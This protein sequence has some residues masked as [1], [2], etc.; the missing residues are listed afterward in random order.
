MAFGVSN[1]KNTDQ[2]TRDTDASVKVAEKLNSD[3]DVVERTTYGAEI[4]TTET[5]VSNETNVINPALAGQVSAGKIVDSFK[6]GESYGKY[7][8]VT[9]TTIESGDKFADYSA[10]ATTTPA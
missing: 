6:H 5:F 10:P 2:L 4:K 7:N 1:P 3:G 8:E 9:I